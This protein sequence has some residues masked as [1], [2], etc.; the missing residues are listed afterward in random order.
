MDPCDTNTG[1]TDTGHMDT[2]RM[3]TGRTDTGRTDTA[4]R[5]PRPGPA[6][7][8]GASWVPLLAVSLGYF[9][10]ILDRIACLGT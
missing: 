6:L 3:N 4:P 1:R 5:P 10:V 7:R 9:M 8:G 2:G